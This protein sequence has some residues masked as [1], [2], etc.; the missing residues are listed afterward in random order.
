MSCFRTY[1]APPLMYINY[2]EVKPFAL[3]TSHSVQAS[4]LHV[5]KICALL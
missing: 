5:K 1:L 4:H 2:A 3:K